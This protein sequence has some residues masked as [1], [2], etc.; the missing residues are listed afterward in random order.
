MLNGFKEKFIDLRLPQRG[1]IRITLSQLQYTSALVE[2]NIVVPIGFKT[3]LGSI[4][5]WLQWLFPKDGRAV[6]AYI[7]HDWLFKD[8]RY[9]RKLSNKIAIEAMG[10]LGAKWWRRKGVAIGLKIG[11]WYAWNKHRKG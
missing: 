10:T 3:D 7:L 1:N 9:G 8:G 6:L 2:T 5:N 4:P 11:S